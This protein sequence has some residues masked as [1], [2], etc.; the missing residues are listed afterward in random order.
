LRVIAF[1]LA[2]CL[3]VLAPVHLRAEET[4][5]DAEKNPGLRT[6]IGQMIMVGFD[7]AS[8]DDPSFRGVLKKARSGKITGVLYLQRNLSQEANIRDMNDALQQAALPVLTAIDQEGGAIQR[9][10][11]ATGFPRIPSASEV[12]RKLSP[13][14][15]FEAYS[16]L[17]RTL[18]D[19]GFNMNFGPVADLNINPDNPII[20]KLGRSFSK[21]PDIV[22]QYCAAFVEA[23]RSFNVLTSLK[24][25]PG[26]GS[27]VADTH[28]AFTDVSKLSKPAELD[29]FRQLIAQ[30]Y[31]DT[32]MVGHTYDANLQGATKLPS[33]LD[34]KVVSN[35]LRKKLGFQS[36]AITDD[37]QMSA[38]TE[39]HTLTDATIRAV[40]AGNNILVFGNSKS[41]DPDIDIK[42]TDI[43]EAAAQKDERVRAAIS[44]SYRLVKAMKETIRRET[45]G[46]DGMSTRSIP[47]P[48]LTPAFIEDQKRDFALVLPDQRW[49]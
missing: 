19:W 6:M 39:Q 1:A 27:S 4:K 10:P 12:A 46:I 11:A 28:V 31:A 16:A 34:G 14:E 48:A 13:R 30:G 21:R 45:P 49:N 33:V 24:H 42:V 9:I 32:V 3:A 38:V 47:A 8:T 41:V 37:L 2:A 25:F 23:H 44:R 17:A 22:V 18:H 29:V 5:A 26:H 35:I 7:G 20:G 43:L 36:V 15:A 40:L